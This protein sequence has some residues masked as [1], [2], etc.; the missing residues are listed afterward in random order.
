MDGIQA[1]VI[2]SLAL[3]H[4]RSLFPTHS[5][6]RL[7][8]LLQQEQQARQGLHEAQAMASVAEAELTRAMREEPALISILA[9]QVAA[10]EQ[11]VTTAETIH[12]AAAGAVEVARSDQSERDSDDLQQRVQQLGTAFL[13][14]TDQPSDRHAINTLLRRLSIQVHIDGHQQLIGLSVA[15]GDVDWQPLAADLARITLHQGGTGLVVGPHGSA[16]FDAPDEP[17]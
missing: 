17:G 10:A 14:G 8:R 2:A 6:D 11:S 12:L 16:S 5:G 13:N 1:Q 15:G 3:G 7:T 4:W 9:R